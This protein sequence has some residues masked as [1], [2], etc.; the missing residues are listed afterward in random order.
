MTT[1]VAQPAAPI[2]Y[3]SLTALDSTLHL[4]WGVRNQTC[5]LT[6]AKANAIPLGVSEFWYASA[7]YPIVFGP[8]GASVFPVAI[9]AIVEGHNL[10]I[11]EQGEWAADTYIPAWLRRYPFWMQP[12]PDGENASLWFDPSAQQVVPLHEFADAKPLFDF[13]GNPNLA[14]ER[15]IQFCKQCQADT[16]HTYAFMQAL[17]AHELLLDRQ[18]SVELSPGNTY[19]LRGFRVIDMAK[20][21]QLPD[22]VLAQWVR[23]GWTSLI[24]LHQV[25]LQ[26]N[27][28]KLLTLHRR[29]ND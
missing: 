13:L 15:I 28:Q 29:L 9:T 24:A 7:H 26:H 4:G 2:F 20:Y 5:L 17:E 3:N 25:S 27:W 22:A 6:A 21:H 18:V 8:A 23:H 11:D 19:S 14:L 16:N 12:D 1:A 10:F